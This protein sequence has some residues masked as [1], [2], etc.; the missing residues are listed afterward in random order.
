MSCGA[1]IWHCCGCAVGLPI[2]PLAWELP[3][4]ADAALKRKKNIFYFFFF[5]AAE[6]LGSGIKLKQ[7]RW[8][9]QILN[10]LSHQGTPKDHFYFSHS[11]RRLDSTTDPS[12]TVDKLVK[13]PALKGCAGHH[14]QGSRVLFPS[15]LQWAGNDNIRKWP[16]RVRTLK[17]LL[18]DHPSSKGQ[19]WEAI[20]HLFL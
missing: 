3:Y 20:L 6:F 18:I 16:T 9:C 19:S 5:L 14:T 11:R 2:W 7:H 10:P 13:A 1:W 17:E 12:Q 15:C 8:Q 4:A